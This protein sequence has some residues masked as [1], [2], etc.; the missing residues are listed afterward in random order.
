MDME[1]QVMCMY[2]VMPRAWCLPVIGRPAAPPELSFH[3][4]S[5]V[6][7]PATGILY[8]NVEMWFISDCF[9]YS[10][11]VMKII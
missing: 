5:W 7:C 10:D 3:F 4:L 8:T 11:I 2:K 6:S 1:K 9:I